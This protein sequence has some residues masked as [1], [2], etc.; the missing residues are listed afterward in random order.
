ML[1]CSFSFIKIDESYTIDRK[2]LESETEALYLP[3]KEA[4]EAI[5][6]GY[7]NFVSHI[8]WFNTISYF[9]KHYKTDGRYTWLA[10]MCELVTSLNTKSKHVYNFCSTMLSWEAKSPEKSI[11]LLNKAINTNPEM[12]EYYYLRG[13]NYMYFLKDSSKAQKDFQKGATLAN[14]PIFLTNLATK[15]LA[16]LDKPEE[17]ISF[18]SNMIKN[19][20]DPTQRSALQFRLEQVVDDLNLKNLEQAAKIYKQKNGIYPKDLG[21]LVTEG[22]MQNIT[23]DLP[24]GNKYYINSKTGAATSDSSHSRLRKK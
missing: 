6:V 1:I 21:V 23:P 7:R 17:A 16:L 18:L 9:G 13:F 10:H 14:A 19:S 12:W 15:K 5:S 3:K 11:S 8:I 4:V 2:A 20:N 24:W 22:I